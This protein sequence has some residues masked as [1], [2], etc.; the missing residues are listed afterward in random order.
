MGPTLTPWDLQAQFI[1]LFVTN[2]SQ[3]VPSNASLNLL[4][5]LFANIN[6][7]CNQAVRVAQWTTCTRTRHMVHMTWMH[8]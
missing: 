8:M 1:D 6:L 2:Q 3:Y 7:A 5:G 4:R